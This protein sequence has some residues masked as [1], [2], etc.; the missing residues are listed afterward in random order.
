MCLFGPFVVL[1][2]PTPMAKKYALYFRIACALQVVWAILGIVAGRYI[3]SIFLLLLAVISLMH[4]RSEEGYSLQIMCSFI[5]NTFYFIW[6]LILVILAASGV[7]VFLVPAE[8]A[9]NIIFWISVIG[10][11]V[12]YLAA[13]VFAKLIYNEL[14]AVLLEEMT[15]QG[16]DIEGGFGNPMYGG[17]QAPRAQAY[18]ARPA[19]PAAAPARNVHSTWG[20]SGAVGSG[21][22]VNPYRD[23]NYVPGRGYVNN[24]AGSTN[25]AAAADQPAPFV[26]FQGR[27]HKLG[28]N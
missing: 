12:I 14:R 11:P 10:G 4:V 21:P 8:G 6:S 19:Q 9:F 16:G 5:M 1:I 20:G 24:T 15:R 28:G 18:E 25:T 3:D 13:A 22:A 26:P 17:Q 23:P 27:G 2:P 7:N